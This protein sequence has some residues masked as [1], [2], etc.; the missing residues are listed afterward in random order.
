MHPNKDELET[1]F[2]KA[3]QIALELFIEQVLPPLH[4]QIDLQSLMK[5]TKG[6]GRRRSPLLPFTKAGRL[7]GFATKTPSQIECRNSK[8]VAFNSL[9][10]CAGRLGKIVKGLKPTLEYRNNEEALWDLNK[11]KKDSLPDAYLL[12]ISGPSSTSDGIK[13]DAIGVPGVYNKHGTKADAESNILKITRCMTH[14]I[15]RNPYRRFVHGFTVEDSTMRLWYCDRAR[16][17]AS[18]PFNFIKDCKMLFH[19]LLSLLFA[20]HPQLGYDPT[21]TPVSQED[22]STQYPIT[23]RTQEGE[24]HVY[25]TMQLLSESSVDRLIGRGTRVWKAIEIQ[26]GQETGDPV[27][28]KDAWVDSHREREG[29]IDSRIRSA[30]TTG[31]RLRAM[32]LLTVLHHG[33]VFIGDAQDRTLVLQEA[34]SSS[35]PITTLRKRSERYQVHYRI[36]CKEIG[37]PLYEATSLATVFRTLKEVAYGLLLLYSCGWVHGDISPGNILLVDGD[38]AKIADLEYATYKDE[39]KE[40]DKIGTADFISTEVERHNYL[41][42]PYLTT[43]PKHRPHDSLP[44]I[45]SFRDLP[46]RPAPTG[47]A[48]YRA[49]HAGDPPEATPSVS[50]DA[51]PIFRYNAIHDLESLWWIA[52]YF[53]VCHE[54]VDDDDNGSDLYDLAHTQ[55]NF[56]S[57]LFWTADNRVHALTNPHYFLREVLRLHPS[58][59]QIGVAL[60]EIREEMVSLYLHVEEDIYSIGF[61]VAEALHDE[62][63]RC[64]DTLWRALE[65]KDVVVRPLS[66]S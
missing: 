54:V 28:L 48:E 19:F 2:G 13:W 38:W 14:C 15:Q 41:F 66:R 29:I 64:F 26:N 51:L 59:R 49:E 63:G 1:P 39:R 53:I 33:D 30:P 22:G 23:V 44:L 7:W 56:A 45:S 50:D 12:A 43:A 40:H 32:S 11:R 24:E 55:R 52:V 58:V 8:E 37:T 65:E 42:Q 27:A 57:E 47:R 21:M 20:D 46:D 6:V 31:P 18:E 9:R 10:I 35:V 60:N 17:L 5:K 16:I 36:V 25:Q 62:F 61:E 34:E 4:P 3:R